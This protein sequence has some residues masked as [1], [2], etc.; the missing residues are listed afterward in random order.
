MEQ[1]KE[2]NF[3]SPSGDDDDLSDSEDEVEDDVHQTN[4][5]SS[6]SH[7]DERADQ[8]TGL[9]SHLGRHRR[10]DSAPLASNIID[11][12]KGAIADRVARRAVVSLSWFGETMYSCD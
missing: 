11:I 4:S 1:E 6:S 9:N 5:D 2:N 3:A 12:E 7:A 10:T 8:L